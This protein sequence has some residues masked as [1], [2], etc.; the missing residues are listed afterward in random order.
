MKIFTDK[1]RPPE[2][3]QCPK[4]F[5]ALMY[6][7]WHSNAND[8][9]SLLFIKTI[10]RLIL[11]ILPKN[12]QDCSTDVINEVKKQCTN[13]SNTLEKYFPH[14]PRLN[15]E[16]SMN[17]YEEHSKKLKSISDIKQEISKLDEQVQEICEQNKIKHDHHKQLLE[18]NRILKE[19]I[20]QLRKSKAQ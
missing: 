5:V 18:E 15:N 6:R 17:L 8:R 11:N 7:S 10:L 3:N 9:P 1:L 16:R 20:E 13:E 19:Q 14:E 12:K 2:L 4:L